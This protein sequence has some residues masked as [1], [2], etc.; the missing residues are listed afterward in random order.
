MVTTIN[1]GKAVLTHKGEWSDATAYSALDWV[2]HDGS[3]YVCKTDAPAGTPL[4]NDTY[5]ILMAQKGADGKNILVY[6]AG[7]ADETILAA[8]NEGDIIFKLEEMEETTDDDGST[9]DG[10]DA[11]ENTETL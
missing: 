2:T 6:T 9:D 7:E 10:T 11:G 8:T 4:T 3:T 1:V 5:W